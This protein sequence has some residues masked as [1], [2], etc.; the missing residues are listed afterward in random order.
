MES[1]IHHQLKAPV[2]LTTLAAIYDELVANLNADSNKD[3]YHHHINHIATASNLWLTCLLLENTNKNTL[4]GS[5]MKCVHDTKAKVRLLLELLDLFTDSPFQQLLAMEDSI[6]VNM[7]TDDEG[8]LVSW[9]STKNLMIDL[10]KDTLL[11]E[12]AQLMVMANTPIPLTPVEDDQKGVGFNTITDA[13]HKH[14]HDVQVK[15]CHMWGR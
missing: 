11:E 3:N 1:W 5:Q 7:Q 13:K 9:D 10:D 15:I 14:W 12:E 2:K 8:D 6:Q 4:S